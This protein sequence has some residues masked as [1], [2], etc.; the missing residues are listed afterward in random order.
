MPIAGPRT[1]IRAR[2]SIHFHRNGINRETPPSLVRGSV[3]FDNPGWGYVNHSSY[4]DFIDMWLTTWQAQ[5]T[6]QR[7]VMKSARS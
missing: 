7:R 3:V 2:Y 5:L 4:V 1:N 6:T